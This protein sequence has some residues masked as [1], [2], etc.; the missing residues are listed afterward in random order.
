MWMYSLFFFFT[1]SPFSTSRP[2]PEGFLSSVRRGHSD[3]EQV[4]TF[5]QK[6]KLFFFS[7]LLLTLW[8]WW[9]HLMFEL[10]LHSSELKPIIVWLLVVGLFST[11]NA[12]T[13]TLKIGYNSIHQV[14]PII[15]LELEL[16]VFLFLFG[17]EVCHMVMSQK[18]SLTQKI[19]T[20]F[21]GGL[22]KKSLFKSHQ[23]RAFITTIETHN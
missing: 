8:M 14:E 15:L 6:N 4:Q 18:D 22:E 16:L 11:S 23:Q 12:P 19:R 9:K 3:W 5:G 21:G 17:L 13:W 1:Q 20:V 2:L 10:I 7:F